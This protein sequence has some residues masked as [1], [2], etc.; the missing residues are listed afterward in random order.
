MKKG[1]LTKALILDAAKKEFCENG[2][3][4]ARMNKITKSLNIQPSWITYYFKDKQNLASELYLELFKNIN[5]KIQESGILI[6]EL[7]QFHFVRIRLLYRVIL[8][9]EQTKQ[10]FYELNKKNINA[11]AT[12]SLIDDMYYQIIENYTISITETEFRII[13]DIDSAGRMSFFTNYL[14]GKYTLPLDDAVTI[15]EGVVPRLIGIRQETIDS[16]MLSSIR[17][18]NAISIED[19]NLLI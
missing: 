15:L 3:S 16:L 4:N 9:D 6:P 11:L 2:Y 12:L 5:N 10:F 1:E 17:I 19:L 7:L 14:E 8:K 18:A 13:R